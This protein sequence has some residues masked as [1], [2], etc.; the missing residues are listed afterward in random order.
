M[1][2]RK[3]SDTPNDSADDVV[4]QFTGKVAHR[5][6]WGAVLVT[7]PLT[8]IQAFEGKWLMLAWLCAFL[9]Y[10]SITALR[11]K[12]LSKRRGR[13]IIFITLLCAAVMYSTLV[14]GIHGLLWAYPVMAS[15][16]FLLSWRLAIVVAVTFVILLTSV[17]LYTI[18]PDVAWRSLVSLLVLM[19][20]TLTLVRLLTRMQRHFTELA[21]TDTLTG[22]YNRK[23]LQ[24]DLEQLVALKARH[25]RA[26]SAAL[27][28]IDYFKDVNDKYGHFD[29]DRLLIQAAQL[30]KSNFRASDKVFRVG[31]EEFV[32]LMPDTSL[33]GATQAAEKLRENF[34]KTDFELKQDPVNMTISIGVSELGE[35]ETWLDWLERADKLLYHAKD[36]GRNQVRNTVQ[37]IA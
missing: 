11:V 27:C 17:S 30:I 20:L 6:Y 22:V 8:I 12:R 9:C 37:E 36:M 3:V 5:I 19:I 23:Q 26:I 2:L 1:D 14:N 29:G 7:L 32:I 35:D 28:D 34:A 15:I 31:G 18:E 16:A 33:A 24:T 25:G 13:H 4:S 10:T 21:V